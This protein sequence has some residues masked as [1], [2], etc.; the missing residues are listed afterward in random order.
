GFMPA[1]DMSQT[2][3]YV[4]MQPGTPLTETEKTAERAR[5]LIMENASVQ[6]V[7][8]SIGGGAAGGDPFAGGQTQEERKATLTVLLKPRAER[9]V[10]QEIEADIRQRLQVIPGVRLK[11][12]LG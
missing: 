8:T 9:P 6:S 12:G 1:D 5:R 7:Y 10:K 2:Q 4:E 3:V 11:V